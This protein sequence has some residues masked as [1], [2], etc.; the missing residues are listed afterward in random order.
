MHDNLKQHN[1]EECPANRSMSVESFEQVVPSESQQQMKPIRHTNDR[2]MQNK[3][4]VQ[5]DYAKSGGTKGVEKLQQQPNDDQTR[6]YHFTEFN[7]KFN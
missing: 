4:N 5:H 1:V 2:S 6:K 7:F 3:S